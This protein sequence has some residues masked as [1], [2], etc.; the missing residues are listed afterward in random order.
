ME[1]KYQD[2]FEMGKDKTEYYLLTKDYVSTTEFEGKEVL[3]VEPEG[4]TLLA[5]TAMRDC[6]F[7]LRTEHQQQ[8]AK[9]LDDPEASENDKY[10]AVTMLRNAE[11]AAKG[12]LP[13]CQDTG[14]ATVYARKG[15]L[16]YTDGTDE[17]F[18]LKGFIRLIRRRICDIRRMLP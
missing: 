14:T 18:C 3:K 1:F 15:H 6:N 5:K 4:L 13:F 7:L 12:V 16:V 10:V 2:P 8:V 11:I 9:I 17:K